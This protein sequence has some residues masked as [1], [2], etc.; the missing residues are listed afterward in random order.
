MTKN[1][2][3]KMT[4]GTLRIGLAA[5]LLLFGL[6][7]SAAE[8]LPSAS[9]NP[10]GVAVVVKPGDAAPALALAKAG[11]I[12]YALAADE[13]SDAMLHQAAGAFDGRGLWVSKWRG[14][15]PLTDESVDL[16]V[17]DVDA[18][19]AKRVLTPVTGAAVD[20]AGKLRFRVPAPAGRDEWTHWLHGPDNN[21]VSLDSTFTLPSRLAWL[22]LPINAGTRAAAGRVAAGGR[23]FLATGV[24]DG[25]QDAG[26]PMCCELTCRSAYHGG[27]IWRKVLPKGF[28]AARQV[29][30]AGADELL[31]ADGGSVVRFNAATGDEMGRFTLDA[32]L[33]IKWLVQADSRLLAMMGTPDA[34]P[35]GLWGDYQTKAAALANGKLGY[36]DEVVCLDPLTGA[37]RWLHHSPQPI[38]SRCIAV[39]SGSLYYLAPTGRVASLDVTTGK[40][41]WIQ[42]D[43]AVLADIAGVRQCDLTV[44][45]EDRPG[46]LVTADALYFALSDGTNLVALSAHDGSRLWQKPRD[47]GRSMVT[48]SL[49]G[50]LFARDVKAGGILDPL[51][52]KGIGQFNGSGCGL[53]TASPGL[54]FSNA[55]GI[56]M[57]IAT[58]ANLPGMPLKTQCQVGGFV[59][60]GRL[61]Y[62][63]AQCR[64]P[65]LTGCIALATGV[66]AQDLPAANS[67]GRTEATLSPDA[68]L[69]I[70]IGDWPT[71]RA[72][73]KHSGASVVHIAPNLRVRWQVTPANPFTTP[74]RS[75]F[76]DE[77]EHQPM[78]PVA[79]GGLVVVAATDGALRAYDQAT[80]A[81][82]WTA[83]CEGP[84][85]GT[86]TIV[87]G[88]VV[89]AAGDG[90]I[91]AFSA[92]D[93]KRRW[94]YRLA[95]TPESISLYGLPGS[96]WPANAPVVVDSGV[97]YAVAGM[98]LST[99]TTVAAI[100]LATGSPRW[101]VRQPWSPSAG[102]A[103]VGG[104]LWARAFFAN[105]P[106]IRLDPA[107]GAAESDRL[108]INGARGREI[109]QVSPDLIA[110]GAS[111][112]H[113]ATDDWG[114]A[115]GEN[116]A[117]M[118]LDA[119]G[120][121]ELP[122]IS[123][124]E[125]SNL[126]P[127]GDSD[128]LVMAFGFGAGPVKLEGWD[129]AKT[130]AY[131][132]AQSGKVDMAKLPN[133][134][135]TQIPD[136][137]NG[138][139][140]EIPIRW[141]PLPFAVRA[142]ALA[143]DGVVVT[144]AGE[145][146]RNR[147]LQTGWKLLVLDR[148]DGKTLQTIALPSEPAPDGLCLTRDG[149]A[150][151]TLRNGGVIC[152]GG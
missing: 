148:A 136:P 116:V 14:S 75:L 80:G 33:Q 127:A 91:Y 106:A 27:I 2:V 46:L 31:I 17:G 39:A 37:Q 63:P 146:D 100:D 24:G 54:L 92:A 41:R 18:T 30:V 149:G 20:A 34:P 32:Q 97:V 10:V 68:D 62:P 83:W 129:T 8:P 128:L 67:A 93:G 130:T 55:G 23:I 87:G 79:A 51:T 82:R 123:V 28:R 13:K 12:V 86:P 69:P 19:E 73:S 21:P 74:K 135:L 50:K 120:R 45:L 147:Q 89:V 139:E 42:T 7:L 64:C 48:L 105:A 133:W 9:L 108:P 141:G 144:I 76:P 126:T 38:D 113:H 70:A 96:P 110:Y 115:R 71:H 84:I 124:A 102:L 132:R 11:W 3:Q 145:F 137:L 29:M 72:D 85:Y 61:V 112:V 131:V 117:L 57:N 40:E 111:E 152:V 140:P 52:G 77:V 25:G 109:V 16:V 150:I 56:T 6:A 104:R 1:I 122:G 65:V 60:D 36:G 59:T 101:A 53:I 107:T 5:L 134:R 151:V 15:I 58:G 114:C 143:H 81:A 119:A 121:P 44:G 4:S 94:R 142:V 99:G 43:T 88:R 66:A 35:K 98:P 22:A 103:L 95:P 138:T 125:R 26:T 90:A 47:G 118:T 49:P 78:P